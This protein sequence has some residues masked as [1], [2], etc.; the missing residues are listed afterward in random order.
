MGK[1]RLTF[2]VS[3]RNMAYEGF[4]ENRPRDLMDALAK[5]GVEE[6]SVIG[7]FREN[8][9]E[10]DQYEDEK[11]LEM[12]QAAVATRAA[13][14]ARQGGEASGE[15]QST[16]AVTKHVDAQ[17][18]PP[19]APEAQK[20]QLSLHFKD[21]TFTCMGY[22]KDKPA[23]VLQLLVKSRDD[24]TY[25]LAI[26]TYRVNLPELSASMSDEMIW[27]KIAQAIEAK[28][29]YPPNIAVPSA[30]EEEVDEDGG[31]QPLDD[32]DEELRNA[33]NKYNAIPTGEKEEIRG[34]IRNLLQS[35]D[36]DVG[37]EASAAASIDLAGTD[38]LDKTLSKS[39][40]EPRKRGDR[41]AV[42]CQESGEK[43]SA[44]KVV[45]I[46]H[47]VTFEE[48][49]ALILK[50]YG[51]AMTLSFEEDGDIVEIDD[52]D[53]L[54]MFISQ[55]DEGKKLKLL[56]SKPQKRMLDSMM[57][58]RDSAA[59]STTVAEAFSNGELEVSLEQTFT[60]HT[61]AVY[62]CA[63]SSSGD[64]FVSVSRD[65]SVRLWNINGK[66][67]SVLMKGGHNG[68]VLSCDFSPLG[69]R[70]VSSCEDRSIK[71]WNT[72]TL[73]KAASLKGHT[74]KVYCVQYSP[75]GDYIVSGS[76]DKVVRV[77]SAETFSREATLKG[78]T[79][80]VFSCG[81][82]RADDG[83]R[84]VSGSDDRL[85]KIWLWESGKEERTIRGHAGTI[86]SVAF[87][88]NDKW[89]VSASMAKELRLWSAETG[90][91]VRELA[92]HATPIHHAIFS[93]KD[94]YILSCAR[95]CSVKVWNTETGDLV[96]T[97]PCHN[98]TVYHM[99][100]LGDSL[101]TCSLDTTV[102]LWK[103]KNLLA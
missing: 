69:S 49:Q 12:F 1:E 72:R 102:K 58:T 71:V 6:A 43:T 80:P 61:Q 91:C 41:L 42:Y 66:T 67:E 4:V 94:K 87:S 65:R 63:F 20:E 28:T 27:K 3:G 5:L 55:A 31:N 32:D 83:K 56:C 38:E 15:P 23:A 8:I 73:A 92:G 95:D 60:G 51:S 96:E 16:K 81:F 45:Y 48:L 7:T 40:E 103:L 30:G 68:L 52:D 85:I 47:S 74:D 13:R 70:V 89:I 37:A 76:C 36:G 50:K 97:I 17:A 78:H 86:W 84:V 10:H 39:L 75:K 82:S 62:F 44:V 99:S 29:G 26:E 14:K 54:S 57:D 9:D 34:F 64:R 53:V 24:L 88:H 77:W 101:L 59:G 33:I 35:G 100:L 11:I 98:N 21:R 2:K 19:A 25:E 79:M 46:S 90:E 22:Q 93:G 18:L